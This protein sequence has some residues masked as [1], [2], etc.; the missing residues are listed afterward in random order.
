[1]S[2]ASFSQVWLYFRDVQVTSRPGII[3]MNCTILLQNWYKYGWEIT[4]VAL[5][6][7]TTNQM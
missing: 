3:I 4:R 6:H 2:D 1:M 7:E 5:K